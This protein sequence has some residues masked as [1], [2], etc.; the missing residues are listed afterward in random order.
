MTKLHINGTMSDGSLLED[1]TARAPWAIFDEGRQDW[2][3]TGIRFLWLARLRLM[4]L[5]R[6]S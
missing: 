6:T 1:R 4:L 5:A 3:V 2:I